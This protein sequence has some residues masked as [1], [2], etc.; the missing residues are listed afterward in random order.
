MS[1]KV[2]EVDGWDFDSG[3]DELVEWLKDNVQQDERKQVIV[4]IIE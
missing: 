1:K 2:F 4:E 3:T